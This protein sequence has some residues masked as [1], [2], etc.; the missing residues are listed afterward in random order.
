MSTNFF[1]PDSAL[2]NY[3][4]YSRLDP[5][6]LARLNR[7][8][9]FVNSPVIITSGFRAG[10]TTQHGLGKAV[11]IVA[12]NFPSTLLDLY[13]AAERIGFI[14]IGVYPDWFYGSKTNVIGGLHLDVRSG[15]A[16]R[17]LGVKDS[18][19]KNQYYVLSEETLKNFGVIK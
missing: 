12:P 2:D 19:G 14:G 17:W 7:F 16:A 6:L 9:L 1:P 15:A 8:R 13:L 10:S 5:I 3:G 4:D 18:D 11:D